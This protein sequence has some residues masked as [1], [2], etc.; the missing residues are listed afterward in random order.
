MSLK[1]ERLAYKPFEYPWAYDA[2]KT[3]EQI[4]WL[5]DE[6]PMTDDVAQWN[7]LPENERHFLTHIFRFFTQ[8]DIE[9]SNCYMRKYAGVFKPTEVQMMLAAFANMETVHIDAYSNLIDTLGLPETEYSAFLEYDEM[10]DKKNFL[11][12]FDVE[13]GD[14]NSVAETLAI[15]GAFTEG[16]QLFA[17]FAMLMNFP[18][19]NKMKGMGQVITWSVRD[20]TLHCEN[21]I[22]LFHTWC[23]EHPEIDMDRLHKDIFAHCID[24]IKLEEKFIDLAFELGDVQGLSANEVKDYIRYIGNIRLEQLGVPYRL[25]RAPDTNP[26]PWMDELLGGVEHANFFEARAT[27]YSKGATQGDWEFDKWHPLPEVTEPATERTAAEAREALMLFEADRP[28]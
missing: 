18:R 8:A 14:P 15:F 23:F 21:I 7:K 16:L 5:V 9:V 2:W 17:S 22:R 19:H 4:H 6:I 13:E 27:E 28:D 1:T 25:R 26:L 10:R 11:D 24:S 12:N 20:E 3:Q